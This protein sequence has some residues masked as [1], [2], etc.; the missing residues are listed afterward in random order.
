MLTESYGGICPNCGY[1]RMFIR[2]GSLYYFQYD[3]CPN[4]C[5]AYGSNSF[6]IEAR[7]MEVIEGIVDQM[8]VMLIERKLPLDN[9]G[10]MLYI[11][12]MSDIEEIEGEPGRFKVR[13]RKRARSIDES[14]CTGCGICVE[15]CPVRY[16]AYLPAEV[17]N[18]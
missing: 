4:C 8:K 18:D 7:D 9:I 3:A 6:D 11:E 10:L 17:H 5:F 2:Y 14:K 13:I 12:T 16:Q 1:D 15:N